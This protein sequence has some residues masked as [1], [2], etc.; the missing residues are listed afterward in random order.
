[1]GPQRDTW[2]QAVDLLQD[3]QYEIER[4]LPSACDKKVDLAHGRRF[5]WQV[6]VDVFR[7][8]SSIL[9]N[10]PTVGTSEARV[11]GQLSSAWGSL[12]PRA[13]PQR[14]RSRNSLLPQEPAVHG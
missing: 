5:R 1:M 4:L 10:G 7:N 14:C 11:L 12:P 6:A 13:D 3:R 9:P 8:D 2:L